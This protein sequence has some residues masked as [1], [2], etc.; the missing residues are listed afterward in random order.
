MV[1]T[2]RLPPEITVESG[3]PESTNYCRKCKRIRRSTFF[4]KAVDLTIDSNEMFSVCKDCIDDIYSKVLESEHGAI[5]K[6]VLYLCRKLNVKYDELA[7]ESAIKQIES[8]GWDINKFFGVYRAKLVNVSRSTSDAPIDLSYMDNPIINI[9]E[10][11]LSEEEFVDFRELVD[12][13]GTDVKE[14]IGFLEFNFSKFKQSHKADTYAEIVL[15]KEVCYKMLEIDKERKVNGKA[16]D[17]STKQ[18]ME[19]M[20]NLAISP[21]MVS[22]ANS[23]KNVDTFGIWIKE[24]ETMR[25]AEWVEDKSI[26]A[27]IDDIEAYGEKHLTS[28]MRSLITGNREFS[29][30][31]S[32]TDYSSEEE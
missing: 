4:Y 20:K 9:P 32:E 25:P 1:K 22:A 3:L 14:D 29:L 12:F 27:D 10:T 5:Q 7:I 6:A 26:Y 19:I 31:E 21:S 17:S 13:W 16:P 11:K 28:P 2:R 30:D 8:S 23:G 15:L 24:I 18:L